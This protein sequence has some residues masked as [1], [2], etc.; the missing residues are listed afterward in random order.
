[1]CGNELYSYSANKI[2]VKQVCPFFLI[3]DIICDTFPKMVFEQLSFASEMYLLFKESMQSCPEYLQM[4]TLVLTI[5]DLACYYALQQM[6]VSL[7]YCVKWDASL[8]L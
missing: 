3:H 7:S 4:I 6:L 1:M 5:G 2:G 8:L